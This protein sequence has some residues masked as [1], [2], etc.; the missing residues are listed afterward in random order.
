MKKGPVLGER[1]IIVLIGVCG[2]SW[3]GWAAALEYPC[4]TLTRAPALDGVIDEAEWSGIPE[5]GGFYILG[6]N[7]WALEKQTF[8]RAGRTSEAL[9]FAVRCEEPFPDKLVAKG[10]DGSDLWS[11]DSVEIFFMPEKESNT[12]VQV[13]VNPAGSRWNQKYE[14]GADTPMKYGLWD[15]QARAQAGKTGWTMEMKLPFKL[16]WGDVKDGMRWRM[17]V[18]RNM[19]NEP[20]TE[21]HTTW[22]GLT[23]GFH[24]W[25][26]FNHLAFK[27]NPPADA[28]E[29]KQIEQT[30][31]QDYRMNMRRQLQEASGEYA[32]YQAVV[33][34]GCK[35]AGLRQ[36][37]EILRQDWAEVNAASGDAQAD[38]MR[39]RAAFRKGLD[40]VARSED[41]KIRLLMELL[42][43]DV[44]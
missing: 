34:E 5:A 35:Q 42:L 22:S 13:I 44:E 1:I 4:F 7:E 32:R 38:E 37:A 16:L 18:A 19:L 9:Y 28:A 23:G 20:T 12:Y 33:E 10:Q 6:K 3:M 36:D 31:R 39:L 40:I 11:E 14:V 24:E 41:L 30:L 25:R 2:L 21:R 15:W 43:A 27:G 8:F 17:N 26:L 29:V